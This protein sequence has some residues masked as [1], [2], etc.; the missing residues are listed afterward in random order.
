M[1]LMRWTGSPLWMLL[2]VQMLWAMYCQMNYEAVDWKEIE[3]PMI[4][5]FFNF[6]CQYCRWCDRS[7]VH[8]VE[9][10]DEHFPSFQP[11]QWLDVFLHSVLSKSYPELLIVRFYQQGGGNLQHPRRIGGGSK[12]DLWPCQS[13]WGRFEGTSHQGAPGF[14]C[15]RKVKVQDTLGKTTEEESATEDIKRKGVEEQLEE[16]KIKRWSLLTLHSLECDAGE[17][18]LPGMGMAPAQSFVVRQISGFPY[19]PY[20]CCKNYAGGPEFGILQLK[21]R[22]SVCL[23]ILPNVPY[24]M[25]YSLI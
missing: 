15:F 13:L 5:Y 10:R 1:Q 17:G 23:S 2:C 12:V 8:T 9:G 19:T 3:W 14:C 25:I 4:N 7:T 18:H 24:N 11:L 16:L 6:P 22:G 20:T 21:V